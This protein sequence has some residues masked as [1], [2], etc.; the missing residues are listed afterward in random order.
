MDE[1]SLIIPLQMSGAGI[2]APAGARALC[3]MMHQGLADLVRA[4]RSG[5]LSY[6]RFGFLYC[7]PV[8]LEDP[9]CKCRH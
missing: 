8:S 5:G 6:T 7:L 3:I 2:L 1:R 4:F 9:A